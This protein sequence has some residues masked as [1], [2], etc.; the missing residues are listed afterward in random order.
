[1]NAKEYATLIL[2]EHWDTWDRHYK[3]HQE[4]RASER[5][6]HGNKKGLEEQTP[7][8]YLLW[9]VGPKENDYKYLKTSDCWAPAWDGGYVCASLWKNPSNLDYWT[10]HL[11]GADDYSL[12]KDFL[13]E[14]EA[15]R[16]WRQLLSSRDI[17]KDDLVDYY[18]S[19]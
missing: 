1:M 17:R 15:R 18:F 14:G 19:N 16:E 13:D 4:W 2:N 6:K 11:S 12:S 9:C 5:K 10:I 3:R 7:I 8:E